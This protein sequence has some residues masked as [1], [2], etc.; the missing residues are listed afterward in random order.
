MTA[1]LSDAGMGF[2]SSVDANGNEGSFGGSPFRWRFIHA[3]SHF[4]G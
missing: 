4:E 2:I 3:L 1:L